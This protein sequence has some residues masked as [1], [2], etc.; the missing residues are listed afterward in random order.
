[1]FNI[2]VQHKIYSYIALFVALFH[3][4][5]KLT[6]FSVSKSFSVCGISFDIVC[7]GFALINVFHSNKPIWI[8]KLIYSN[9]KHMM[10]MV[11][12]IKKNVFFLL[13]L[14][15]QQSKLKIKSP[16]KLLTNKWNHFRGC[17]D[18]LRNQELIDGHRE[19]DGDTK[20]YL[21]AGLG[22]QTEDQDTDAH[23][24]HA[25]KDEVVR[26]EHRFAVH[27]DCIRDVDVWLDTARI[28]LDI[29]TPLTHS[30]LNVSMK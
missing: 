7:C 9:T 26:E 8:S 20:R 13:F 19:Q 24:K 10:T 17:R 25:G 21:L 2:D 1:L 15:N 16:K 29:P 30:K 28:I 3:P 23:E 22:G 5:N 18:G 27:D 14:S 4:G 12:S 6:N 11:F